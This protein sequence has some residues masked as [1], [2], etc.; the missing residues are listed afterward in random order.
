MNDS[1]ETLFVVDDD[2]AARKGVVALASSVGIPCET[3]DSA[4]EFLES[5]DASRP[6]CLLL[7]LRLE[8]M[9]GLDLQ[10]RLAEASISRP[11]I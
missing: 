5:Y 1:N 4:E 6:G 8:G 2:P 7:D 11:I 10:D 9:N 3:F